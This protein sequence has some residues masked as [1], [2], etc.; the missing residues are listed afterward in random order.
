[1]KASE[2]EPE[3]EPG[4]ESHFKHDLLTESILSPRVGGTLLHIIIIEIR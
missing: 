2:D 1:M 3:H 4:P